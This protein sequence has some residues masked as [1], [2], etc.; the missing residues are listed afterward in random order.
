MDVSVDV[1]VDV[2][3]DVSMDVSVD[4]S[5]DVSVD[6]FMDVSMDVSVDV[7]MDVSVDVFMDVSMDVSVD[8]S[9]GVFMDV[10]VD[11]SVVYLR[12]LGIEQSPGSILAPFVPQAPLQELEFSPWQ[13]RRLQHPLGTLAQGALLPAFELSQASCDSAL[14][15]LSVSLALGS[16]AAWGLLSPQDLSPQASCRDPGSPPPALLRREGDPRGPSGSGSGSSSSSRQSLAARVRELLGAGPPGI[17]TSQMLRSAEEQERRIRAWVKLKLSQESGPGWGEERQ[18]RMEGAEAELLPRARKPARATDPWL[19]GL[20]AAPEYLRKQEQQLEQQLEPFQ[21]PRDRHRQLS[22]GEL[23]KPS[24]PTTLCSPLVP[25]AHKYPEFGGAAVAQGDS[26]TPGGRRASQEMSAGPSP[27]FSSRQQLQGRARAQLRA[28]GAQGTPS[29]APAAKPAGRVCDA[30]AQITVESP[31]R[32]SLSAEICVHPQEKE[33]AALR[34]LPSTPEPP[35]PAPAHTEI[36]PFPRQPA[37]PLLLPYKPWGST[38][39]YYVPQQQSAASLCP[40]EPEA[41]GDSSHSGSEEAPAG[42]LAPV[43]PLRDNPN[44]I[45]AAQQRGTAHGH[46]ARPELAWPEE[47]RTPL[48]R[49][50]ELAD[51]GRSVKPPGAVQQLE[52][53]LLSS[54]LFLQGSI[55]FSWDSPGASSSSRGPSSALGKKRRARMLNKGI[56]AGALEIVSSATRRNT[57]DVGVTFPTPRS[58]QQLQ[59]PPGPSQE[60]PAGGWQQ[61]WAQQGTD[62]QSTRRSRLHWQQGTPWLVPAEDVQCDWRK[63]NQGSAPAGPG[64]AWFEPWGSA[65]PRREPLRERNWERQPSS[66]RGA[67]RGL[68]QPQAK[69]SLQEAL[70]LRRPDFISRSGQRLR[71]LRLLREER[72]LHR[73]QLAQLAQLLPSQGEQLEQLRPSQRLLQPAGKRKEGRTAAHLVSDRGFL[74]KERRRAIP[75]KEMLQRSKRIYEQ[76]PEVRRRREEEQRRLE[77][78]SY[79][80]RAQLYKTKITNRV[81]GKKVSWS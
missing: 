40:G 13:L 16:E 8:V 26:A 11:V 76:L 20:E 3:M 30:A 9:M 24:S 57:R 25:P 71:H 47:Q 70:A 37:Q 15:P 43:L 65:Q 68:G 66:A 52:E 2:S 74:M 62:R 23:G 44:P 21:A 80:L 19:C 46:R 36:P 4:V 29:S 7:S 39:M 41:R 18:P 58:S 54:W 79:R 56:Q 53:G 27:V 67:A 33:S 6:V 17:D 61:P 59:E 45:P 73:E 1:S 22:R 49:F 14:S 32:S 75:K 38:G 10:S 34:S 5:M 48:E 55:P 72:R 35:V 51:G 42:L 78:S 64:P 69:L 63:E 81:L 31:S 28:Q 12:N 60:G 50:S 77:Y